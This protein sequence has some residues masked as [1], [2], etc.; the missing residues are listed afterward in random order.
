[1]SN[2]IGQW[3]VEIF[4]SDVLQ[5]DNSQWLWLYVFDN[6]KSQK[7]GTDA[8]LFKA[9]EITPHS[10]FTIKQHGDQNEQIYKITYRTRYQ[11]RGRTERGRQHSRRRNVELDAKYDQLHHHRQHWHR[12]R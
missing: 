5:M 6:A 10:G 1:M 3:L 12:V 2:Q 8:A 4:Y 11:R 9:L 7:N